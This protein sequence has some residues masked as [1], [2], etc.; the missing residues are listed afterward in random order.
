MSDVITTPPPLSTAAATRCASTTTRSHRPHLYVGYR[1][2]VGQ[3]HR[4]QLAELLRHLRSTGSFATRRTT[5]TR[6]LAIEVR[7]VGPLEFPVTTAQAQELRF[8]ARP[9]KYGLGEHTVLDRAV[10][11]TWEIPRSRVKIDKRRWNNTLT[12]MLEAV[13]DDLG[14]AAT[15]RLRAELHS[16]LLY[17]PG[18]FFTA[19]QDSEK[20]DEMIGSLVVMLPSNST[21]GDLVIEHLG[22]SV[23]YP[24]STS[25]LTFVAF[26]SDTRHEVLPVEKGYRIALTYNLTLRSETAPQRATDPELTASAAALLQQHFASTPESRWQGDR[27]ALEPPDR[28]VFLL[29]HQYTERGLDWSHLKGDDAARATVIAHAAD[30]ADCDLHLAHAEVHETWDC[31][32]PT[33]PWESRRRHW[34]NDPEGNDMELEGDDMELGDLLDS[35]VHIS[36]VG[37]RGVEFDPYVDDA[38]LAAATP[39]VELTP[40]DTEYTG[41]M[42]NYGN[43]MDRWYRRAAIVVWPRSRTFALLAKAS[44]LRAVH[45]ILDTTDYA[46]R[47]SDMVTTLLRFWP[48]NVRSGDQAA[49]LPLALRLAWELGDQH[50]ATMLLA[51]FG[52]EALTPLDA[53]VLVALSEQH[54][55]DWFDQQLAVWCGQRRRH[56]GAGTTDRA[57]WITSLPELCASV[58]GDPHGGDL[59]VGNL[60]GGA[61]LGPACAQALIGHLWAWLDP[62]LGHAVDI[63]TPSRRETTLVDLAV[64]LLMVLR[65]ASIAADDD[66]RT[67]MVDAVTA[68]ATGL[69]PT[70]VG[71]VEAAEALTGDELTSTGV[72][73]ITRH[74][75]QILDDE[76]ARP[77]RTPGDWSITGIHDDC[78]QDCAHL[79][80]FLHD[81]QQQQM[82]WPL[83]KARRQHIHRRIDEA[84]LPVTHLTRREG[85]PHKLVVTKTDALFHREADRRR[86]AQTWLDAANRLLD[87]AS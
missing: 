42:G 81:A 87:T 60:H 16:M 24:G 76:L 22:K 69:V 82:T 6:D 2:R 37:T 86:C 10:R 72:A 29:D 27:L 63:P 66:L 71:V 25:S 15:T 9:A 43:T 14:L 12:P 35:S 4:V 20:S 38:E 53:T 75:A 58:C 32:D 34:D 65:A 31:F 67:A 54:G 7:G 83:A 80:S 61:A 19:H 44:P 68:R 3:D 49:L 26:Y 46:G 39:S 41:F 74:L 1:R 5:P 28:L 17:E 77:E 52:V 62:A 55:L 56:A 45:Q 11:D 21:G 84:E 50:H 47:A 70:L 85:S 59:H 40:R 36:P 23:R 13:R 64:P 48:D 78:C 51:P 73:G 18:Q 57:E 30:L 79:A 33:P 8:L